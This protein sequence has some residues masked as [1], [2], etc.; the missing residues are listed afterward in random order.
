MQKVKTTGGETKWEQESKETPNL[1]KTSLQKFTPMKQWSNLVWGICTKR[2]L[3]LSTRAEKSPNKSK[4][5]KTRNIRA[6]ASSSTS[7]ATSW[8]S[9]LIIIPL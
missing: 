9:M 1:A 3:Q 6:V 2:F 8:S 7:T 5:L 4:L